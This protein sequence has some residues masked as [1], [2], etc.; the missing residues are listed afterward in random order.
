[1]HLQIIILPIVCPLILD[2]QTY[3]GIFFIFKTTWYIFLG[4]TIKIKEK[5]QTKKKKNRKKIDY[6]NLNIKARLGYKSKRQFY[7]LTQSQN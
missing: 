2:F 3:I 4:F 5:K 1:M 6:K 7:S